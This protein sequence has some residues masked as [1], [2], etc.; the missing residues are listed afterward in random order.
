MFVE[1]LCGPAV[2][3]LGFSLTQVIIDLFRQ[4]YNTAII[5]SVVTIVFTTILNMLCRQ[6]L[7]II[8]WFIVF[9]PFVTMTLVTG[10]L[11]YVFGLAPFT[12]KL[13]YSSQEQP[14]PQ[15]PAVNRQVPSQPE[16]NGVTS[17]THVTKQNGRNGSLSTAA[18]TNVSTTGQTTVYNSKSDPITQV[19]SGINDVLGNIGHGLTDI[20][21]GINKVF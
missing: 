7:G 5:K 13:Q 12:G 2:L 8:S 19:G 16:I 21:S 1:N 18:P 20:G 3:Y 15:N 10:I 14:L 6:G 9:I 11:L 4:A 17:T